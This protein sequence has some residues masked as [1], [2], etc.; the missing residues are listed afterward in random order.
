MFVDSS[1]VIAILARE[2]EAG[3]FAA[4]IENATAPISAG[5]VLLESAMDY[6]ERSRLC[7]TAVPRGR[8]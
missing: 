8:A 1:A 4:K 3:E 7:G 5:H 2:P 6:D